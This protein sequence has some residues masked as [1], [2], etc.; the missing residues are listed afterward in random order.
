M[1]D[2]A[3]RPLVRGL[4]LDPQ[5]RCAHWHSERDIIAIRMRCCGTY[6]ACRECH[7]A[8]AGHD[9]QVWPRAEWNQPTVLCG[10]CGHEL[11]VHEYL[12]CDSRCPD[13]AAAFNPGCKTHHHLYFEPL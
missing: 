3:D 5:T 1:K 2:T 10:A 11:T 12:A 13:C 9:V 8:L 6:F 4:D 7:D